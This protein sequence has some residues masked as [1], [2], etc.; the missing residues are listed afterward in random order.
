MDLFHSWLVETPIAHRG[1]WDKNTPENSLAAFQKAIDNGYAIELEVHLLADGSIAVFHD[2]SLARMTGNDGY[3]KYLYKEDLKLLKLADS[4]ETIPSLE[5]VLSLVN[6][7]VP[8]LI[9]IKNQNK[10]GPLEQALIDTLSNYNG[11]YAVQSFNPYSLAY[12]KKH[13]PNIIRGQLSG[14]FKGERFKNVKLS[15]IAKFALR[16]MLL[17]KKVSEPNF[18]SYEYTPLINRSLSRFKKL[19]LIAWPVS[20]QNDYLKVIKHC[21]NIIF[22]GFEPKI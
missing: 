18:I 7:K 11:Q 3:I 4:K 22:E 13:A 17:N 20:N 6:G 16:H 10:V 15:K 9:E 21:D 1:L 2:D 14:S 12:L 8:L 19:P 5:E